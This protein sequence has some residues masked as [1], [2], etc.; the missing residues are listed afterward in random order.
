MYATT[1][2]NSGGYHGHQIKDE[3]GGRTLAMLFDLKYL[4][5]PNVYLNDYGISTETLLVDRLRLKIKKRLSSVNIS[6]P[7]WDGFCDYPELQNLIGTQLQDISENSLIIFENACRVFPH[8][9][10]PWFDSGLIE[11]D[12]FNH[13]R[14][15]FSQ[16][17]RAQHNLTTQV[18]TQN[19]IQVAIHINRGSDANI[20][21]YPEHYADSANPRYIFEMEYFTNIISQL[22]QFFG[23]G[24]IVFNVYTETSGSEDIVNSLSEMGDV[25]IR[26][27]SDRET[28]KNESI[29]DIF[30][31]FAT[32]D[33][34]VTCNSSF[35]AVCSYYRHGLQTIYHPHKHL[36]FLPEGDFLKTDLTGIFDNSKLRDP[37]F[38]LQKKL[39]PQ[40]TVN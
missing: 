7:Y 34:L 16:R 26:L 19:Q 29:I 11:T 32:A 6:G 30:R 23:F 4:Q 12:I 21:W 28:K 8:Q 31:E 13:I 3:L 38:S 27:G 1:L 39:I 10:I 33:I 22:R 14:R 24:N 18:H 2:H 17:F 40:D 15:D 37:L 20:E 25:A 35:S 9:T 36:E 5:T